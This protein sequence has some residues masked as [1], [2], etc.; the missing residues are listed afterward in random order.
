MA[1][2]HV[3]IYQKKKKRTHGMGS[4]ELLFFKNLFISFAADIIK[5][6]ASPKIE[7]EK[8]ASESL[9]F[10]LDPLAQDSVQTKVS[11]D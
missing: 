6:N 4:E 7:G 10:H 8:K 2:P 5:E 1:H 3:N 11:H 9:I